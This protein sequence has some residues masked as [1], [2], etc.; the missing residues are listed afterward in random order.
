[1]QQASNSAASNAMRTPSIYERALCAD[2]RDRGAYTMRALTLSD[3]GSAQLAA[4]AV[5]RHPDWFSR[6]ERARLDN[7]RVARMIGS[8]TAGISATNPM[9]C[10]G[11]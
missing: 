1:M 8:W 11:S 5:L 7:D 10:A 2:P 9:R 4:E 6:Q 3:L